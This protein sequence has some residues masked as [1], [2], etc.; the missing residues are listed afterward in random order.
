MPSYP[1]SFFSVW[2]RG[3]LRAPVTAL[4]RIHIDSYEAAFHQLTLKGE[5]VIESEFKTSEQTSI[6]SSILADS[7]TD[8]WLVADELVPLELKYAQKQGETKISMQWESD[9]MLLQ[10]ISSDYLLHTLGSETTPFDITVLPANTNATFSHLE[11]DVATKYAIV[12]L[13]KSHVLNA[14][15]EFGNL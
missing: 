14:R 11:D 2:W 9:S 5:V 3:F 10:E 12:D 4:Y 13:E 7:Y 6:G 15:D 8:I 1:T